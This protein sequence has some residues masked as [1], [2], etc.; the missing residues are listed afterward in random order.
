MG[1]WG[2]DIFENDGA[3]DTLAIHLDRILFELRAAIDPEN[4]RH[5]TD[6]EGIRALANIAYCIAANCPHNSYRSADA[7]EWEKMM[8]DAIDRMAQPDDTWSEEESDQ[9][10]ESIRE[11]FGRLREAA[12]DESGHDNGD[13]EKRFHSH[14]EGT[15]NYRKPKAQHVEDAN[16]GHAPE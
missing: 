8:F 2:E 4:F 10:K 1:A 7:E 16:A 3:M 6:T 13:F 12:D 9:W 14:F 5:L 11:E 15:T